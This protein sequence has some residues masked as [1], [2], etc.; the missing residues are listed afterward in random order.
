MRNHPILARL[1]AAS[2][3]AVLLV[4]CSAQPVRFGPVDG[5][6]P[7]LTD[8]DAY[9]AR[10]IRP[11]TEVPDQYPKGRTTDVADAG[12]HG[13]STLEHDDEG[14]EHDAAAGHDEDGLEPDHETEDES[15]EDLGPQDEP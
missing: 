13:T 14:D 11:D 1:F 9:D 12:A 4:G 8:V 6:N 15:D 10:D 5:Y 2:L 7:V 3:L